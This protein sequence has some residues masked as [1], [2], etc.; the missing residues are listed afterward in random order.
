MQPIRFII[1]K[2][3]NKIANK[4]SLFIS[5]NLYLQTHLPVVRC[6]ALSCSA[7]IAGG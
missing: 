7:C 2:T 4:M 1:F 5:D 3:L 6:I